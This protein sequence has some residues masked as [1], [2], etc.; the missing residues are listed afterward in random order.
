[1]EARDYVFFL[2]GLRRVHRFGRQEWHSRVRDAATCAARLAQQAGID[3]QVEGECANPGDDALLFRLDRALR[4]LRASRPSSRKRKTDGLAATFAAHEPAPVQR[5]FAR[6]LRLISLYPYLE[7][8]IDRLSGL[9]HLEFA[10]AGLWAAFLDVPVS[11]LRSALD[12]RGALRGFVWGYSRGHV[13]LTTSLSAYFLDV[14]SP[15]L[16]GPAL[17]A[18][19]LGEPAKPGLALEAFDHLDRNPSDLRDLLAGALRSRATGVFAALIGPPGTGKTTLA[20]AAAAAAGAS[21]FPVRGCSAPDRLAHFELLLRLLRGRQDAIVVFDEADDSLAGSSTFLRML[22]SE[23]LA[24]KAEENAMFEDAPVP[25]ILTSNGGLDDSLMRRASF[26]AEVP[27][28]TVR[29]R[30]TILREMTE[31]R[32]P[33]SADAVA[34]LAATY[35]AAPAIY[36]QA[37]G[38][39]VLAGDNDAEGRIARSLDRLG[40]ACPDLVERCAQQGC[41]PIA[42]DLLEAD[43]PLGPL[44]DSI[45]AEPGCKLLLVGEPGTGKT[46]FGRLVAARL[47]AE[48]MEA[49]PGSILGPYVGQSE[50]LLRRFLR[51]AA[52]IAARQINDAE[53]VIARRDVAQH[54]HDANLTVELLDGLDAFSG[55][56]IIL[57]TNQPVTAVDPAVVSRMDAVITMRPLGPARFAA[58]FAHLLGTPLPPHAHR[59]G[60]TLRDLDIV[61]R[62]AMRL[63]VLAAHDLLTM[64]DATLAAKGR[65]QRVP[66][67]FA[68]TA[69]AA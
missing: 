42:L 50:Q 18:W 59:E 43:E 16:T 54:R 33:L 30:T 40:A 48:L 65:A 58:A 46:Q 57:N 1:M 29:F 11:A 26:V 55:S 31:G 38:A 52:G 15:P 6:L 13:E 53:F 45:R 3:R 64:L 21:I 4:R 8:A 20:H 22:A 62:R 36:G 49:S 39:A 34:R 32:V 63:G 9:L 17:L 51:S 25:V 24:S 10:E 61:R 12:D 35:A 66:I 67:G 69:H 60:V 27:R 41:E 47:D 44:V 5:A 28:P 56:F 37:V 7:D 19:L 23:P 14:T 68:C 2:K